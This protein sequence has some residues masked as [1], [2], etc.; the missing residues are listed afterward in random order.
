MSAS[1]LER[2]FLPGVGPAETLARSAVI[3]WIFL[4][5]ATVSL[6]PAVLMAP[7]VWDRSTLSGALM[8]AAFGAYGLLC[9]WCWNER[10]LGR[11]SVVS[12]TL[13]A[14]ATITFI[15]VAA[16]PQGSGVSTI[17]FMVLPALLFMVTV[18]GQRRLSVLMTAYTT[19]L[20]A[21]VLGHHLWQIQGTPM[22]VRELSVGVVVAGFIAAFALLGD[23]FAQIMGSQVE[24][25]QRTAQRHR[26]LF[27][28]LPVGAMVVEGVLISDH[29][30]AAARMFSSN[31]KEALTGTDF[32]RLV[33]LV[34][35][36]AIHAMIQQA[37]QVPQGQGLP[38]QQLGLLALDGRE[39]RAGITAVSLEPRSVLW[40]VIDRG[41]EDEALRELRKSQRLVRAL[42]T[43]SS[44]VMTVSDRHTGQYLLVNPA[45]AEAAGMKP[46]EMIGHSPMDLGVVS[47]RDRDAML[48]AV[49]ATGQARDVSMRMFSRHGGYREQRYSVTETEFDGRSV[50]VCVG[51]DV[52]HVTRRERELQAILAATPAAISVVRHGRV[53]AASAQYERLFGLTPG[54]S[55]GRPVE[56]DLG[57]APALAA[58]ARRYNASL[59]A[60]ELVSYEH[61]LH[62]VDGSTF[63]GRAT[64][65]MIQPG[66][67]DGFGMVWIF[68]DLTELRSRESSLARAKADAEAANRA[69]T[70]FLATMSHEIRTPLNGIIGLVELVRDPQMQ[71]DQRLQYLDLMSESAQSL[72]EI[73]SD[74]LDL[75]RIESG[76]LILEPQDF[77][78]GAWLD[79]VKAVFQ[80]LAEAKG[81]VLMFQFEP[82]VCGWVHGDPARLRQILANYLA[83][84]LKFTLAGRIDVRLSRLNPKRIRLE[85]R[86]TGIGIVPSELERLFKPYTQVAGGDMRWRGFGLG[87]SI[88]RQLA[89]LM[90]G[91]V[92]ASSQHG[93]GSCFW[94]EVELPKAPEPEQP[95]AKPVVARL[96]DGL[97]LLVVDDNRINLVVAK[98]LLQRAG[99]RV[100]VAEGGLE[101]LDAVD[102]ADAQG[103]PFDLVLM[104]I[105]MPGMDG[106]QALSRLRERPHSRHLCVLAASAAVTTEEVALTR[107]AGFD[108]FVSK[109]LQVQVLVKA[110]ADAVRRTA[111][112]S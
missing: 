25:A 92:G 48:Q 59:R 7:Q 105:Q 102:A 108:G 19:I 11:R 74:V 112:H 106:L 94:A 27:E 18:M 81:L 2:V 76:R 10:R 73:V 31:P 68:E 88:V 30:E 8:L 34:H 47:Q 17:G 55:H 85:V 15:A 36:S 29:N 38:V 37:E 71:A 56:A 91:Q 103:K 42:F 43:S 80:P 100:E 83:N 107:D 24:E 51:H 26:T 22:L 28:R 21:G 97:R 87:L 40:L 86:D 69:K 9:L 13:F 16:V 66:T 98:Q 93:H 57:G 58:I 23:H 75:S 104:D 99:A 78:L 79:T 61:E 110:I 96:L 45:C 60:G 44:H 32:M 111:V 5:A 63:R 4:L 20:W 12:V 101:A 14:A 53:T 89:E 77:E 46:E 1:Q 65:R 6:I 3:G 95:R 90:G 50:L 109:P 64:G 41:R 84:A 33:P 62:R 82:E 67:P 39:V 52:S 72:Q 49:R 54:Q 35:R 70:D